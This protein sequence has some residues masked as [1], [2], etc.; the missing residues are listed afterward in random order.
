MTVLAAAAFAGCGGGGGPA[1]EE[2][3][4]AKARWVQHVEGACRK[5]N[6]AISDR[7]WPADLVDLDRLVVR[8]I[9]D[10]RGA[11]RTIAAERLPQGAGPR[12]ER[13]V[14]ELQR[15]DPE[16]TKLSEASEDLD[17]HALIEAAD[18]LTPRLAAVQRRAE[19]AGLQD[20][21]TH[22][23]RSFIPDAVRAPVFAEQ[24]A[25]LERSLLRRIRLIDAADASSPGEFA[26][27]FDRYSRLID[28]AVEG[29][30]RLDPPAWAQ[31]QIVK[32]QVALRDLQTVTQR[33]ADRLRQDRGKPRAALD[34]GAYLRL[35]GKMDA[36]AAVE[37]KARRKMLRAVGA[38]P[39]TP[40]SA[41]GDGPSEPATTEQS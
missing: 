24:L 37:A 13:F 2:V 28:H 9:D 11:I 29:I 20:C 12:P 32:Y 35:Q 36:A 26:K 39:T 23:E 41:G 40:P 21:V 30:D 1:A 18:A 19:D 31:R 22:D 4:V 10:A 33:F 27:A 8:G 5:A 14:R 7:G 25:R 16:L 34:A 6:A 3:R 17:P 15:L 38:R